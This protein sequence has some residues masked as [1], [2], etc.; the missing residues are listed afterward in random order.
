MAR[1]NPNRMSRPARLPMISVTMVVI[2]ADQRAQSP[3][4]GGAAE[5]F[6]QLVTADMPVLDDPARVIDQSGDQEEYPGDEHPVDGSP[7]FL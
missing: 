2:M 5:G 4:G 7:A 3:D 1:K 6:C